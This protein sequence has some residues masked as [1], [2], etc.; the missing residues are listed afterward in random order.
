MKAFTLKSA[1]VAALIFVCACTKIEPP[2]TEPAPEPEPEPIEPDPELVYPAP[3]P[4]E[5]S[6]LRVAYF[7]YYRDFSVEAFPDSMFNFID[8]ACYAFTHITDIY[9][10][11]ISSPDQARLLIKR[12][13]EHGVKVELCFGG[14]WLDKRFV[15]MS[16]SGELRHK[17][18]DMILRQVEQ[19]GFDGVNNDWEYPSSADGS[20]YGNLLLMRELSN[21]LHAP[22]VGKTLS[23]AINCGK[24]K[25][26]YTN[27]VDRGVFDCCDWLG[28][29]CYDDNA[30]HSPF[31]IVVDSYDYWIGER[32]MPVR[33]FV[34]GLPCYGRSTYADDTWNSAKTFRNLV[35][36]YGADPDED[37][38]ETDGFITDYNGRKTIA[39]KVKYLIE[40]NAGGYFFWEAG[41]DMVDER[42]LIRTA[43]IT[44]GNR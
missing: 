19:L 15:T 11:Q 33:K 21:A 3:D 23:M 20:Q 17:F 32:K 7:P 43:S 25:G 10:P 29:M 6:F 40:K 44:A 12:C 28:T 1:A 41:E 35:L 2:A 8:V 16:R 5:G 36:N 39:E 31:S 22:G 30:P 37:E 38:V 18:V 26:S 14:D 24:Y 13:H 27:G 42:S 34:G 4:A 9:L